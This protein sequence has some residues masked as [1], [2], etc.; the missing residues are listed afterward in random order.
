MN[1]VISDRVVI[2]NI[3]SCFCK[4]RSPDENASFLTNIF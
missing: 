4:N 1:T 2:F 3:S